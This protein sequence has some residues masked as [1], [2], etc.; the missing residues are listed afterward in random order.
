ME[1]HFKKQ[2]FGKPLVTC[3]FRQFHFHLVLLGGLSGIFLGP[4][5]AKVSWDPPDGT[6]SLN[7]H[8]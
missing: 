4:K 6:I 1:S 3:F 7:I 2:M 5:N 8:Y